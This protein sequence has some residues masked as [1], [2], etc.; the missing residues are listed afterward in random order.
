MVGALTVLPAGQQVPCAWCV[1]G[2]Q[3]EPAEGTAHVLPCHAVLWLASLCVMSVLCLRWGQPARVQAP[4]QH[5]S[6]ASAGGFQ[7]VDMLRV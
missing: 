4:S 3:G 1:V 5:N 6:R 7:P 2:T